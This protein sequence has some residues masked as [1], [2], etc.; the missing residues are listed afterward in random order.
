MKQSTK[1]RVLNSTRQII[2]L[3]WL[4]FTLIPIYTAFVASLTKY[5]NLGKTFLYPTDWV[6]H[7]YLEI[8]N[9]LDFAG[10]LKATIIYAI[11]S[12]IIN[13]VIGALAAYAL[14][15]Y[16]FNGKFTYMGIIL[17]TQVLPQVVI[18]VPVFMLMQKIGLYDSYGAIII[19]TVATSMAFPI[20]LMKSFFDNVPYSLEEAAYI[21]G[22]SKI[23]TLVRIIVPLA[24]PGIATA[25]ALSFFT[26]WGQ[27]LFPLVLSRSPSRTP[28]TV[29]ISR[30]IDNSTPWE[31]VMTGTLLSILPPV[32]VYSFVQKSL[33]SGLAAGS[34]KQ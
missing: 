13:V 8:F 21:D 11:G 28:V 4:V 26:G 3:C 1:K 15:R 12:S 10:Y 2:L 30:L 33:I 14:S 5:E 32:I 20:I 9:R 19:S 18:V 23:K 25:F 34:V 22:C 27:Y 29:G 16:S 17:V 7:N 24:A 6:W 31:M